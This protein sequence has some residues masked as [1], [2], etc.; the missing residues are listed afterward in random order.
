M[1]KGGSA[2]NRGMRFLLALTVFCLTIS[3]LTAKEPYRYSVV[4]LK[5][6]T[7]FRIFYS[8]RWGEGGNSYRGQIK[9]YGTYRHWWTFDYANQNWAP[10][11]Y[12][13]M[14]GDADWYRLGSFWSS[15]TKAESGRI[16]A[17]KAEGE[18]EIREIRLF[19]K[20]YTD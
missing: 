7:P 14:D 12:V 9:P 16:Y 2:R 10:W 11:F 3:G 20:L 18:G 5:N 4:T 13:Q 8:Y 1:A 6:E 15:D 17:F 19:E